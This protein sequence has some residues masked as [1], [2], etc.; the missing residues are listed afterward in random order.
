LKPCQS[1]ESAA[2]RVWKRHRQFCERRC[3]APSQIRREVD[4]C[5]R[6][7]GEARAGTRSDL[8]ILI[9][10]AQAPTFFQF[11]EIEDHLS[12][13]LGVKVDL[14]MKSA[15][16]PRIGERILQEVVSI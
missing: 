13:L 16:K 3:R 15:L 5:V 7:L 8:D 11:I 2:G 9:D 1:L 10:F 4:R 6:L 14:V 12:A